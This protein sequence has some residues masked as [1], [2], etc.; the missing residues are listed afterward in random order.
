MPRQKP[1]HMKSFDALELIK[2]ATAIAD[3]I[4][5]VLEVIKAFI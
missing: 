2:T 5:I 3:L 1:K 4:K